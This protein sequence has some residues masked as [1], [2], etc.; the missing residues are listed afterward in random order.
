M[1][2]APETFIRIEKLSEAVH[3][4]PPPTVSP[5]GIVQQVS[6]NTPQY[7]Y[8][9]LNL[10]KLEMDFSLPRGI[11]LHLIDIESKGD[12]NAR[13]RAGAKSLFGIMP[14]GKSGFT[15]NINNPAET[16][17]FAAK[18]LKYLIDHFG[19]VEKGLAAYN[20]GMGNLAKKGLHR[21]PVQTKKYIKFFKSKGIIPQ[22]GVY[23]K[24]SWG[25]EDINPA[26]SWKLHW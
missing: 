21:A 9:K 18:T 15:G 2:L 6:Q 12:P 23:A 11:L 13:S 1:R 10:P 16:A 19:T 17:V 8:D 25:E 26:D 3:A 22:N 5:A 7:W 4:L 24:D 20:W 14:K